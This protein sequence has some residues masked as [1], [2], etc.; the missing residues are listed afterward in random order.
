MRTWREDCGSERTCVVELRN[1]NQT[2]LCARA[3]GVACAR[4]GERACE[5]ALVATCVAT[6]DGRLVWVDS[7][8]PSPATCTGNGECR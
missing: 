4:E 6:N 1:R 5:G 2:P 7:P 8:C 3:Q